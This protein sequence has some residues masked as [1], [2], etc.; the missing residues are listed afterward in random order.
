MD[1]A[2]LDWLQTEDGRAAA[3]DASMLLERS[4][5][6]TA[7]RRLG[8]RYTAEQA[9]AAV[10]LAAGRRAA[11]GKIED[12][13]VLFC[14]REA[15]EQASPDLVAR[16]IAERFPGFETVADLGCGMG[17]DALAIARVARVLAVDR[18]ETRLAMVR[19]NAS[20]RGVTGRVETLR[21]DLDGWSPPTGIEAVWADPARRDAA[22]RRL[23]PE[24]WSPS[25]RRVVEIASG[26]RGAGIKL[27]PGI[28][29]E[30]L[31]AGGEI[32]FVSVGRELKAAVLWVGELT[33][34]SRTATV[35]EPSRSLSG[36]PDAGRTVTGEPGLYLY[37]PDPAVGR[38][39][40]VDALAEQLGAWKLDERIAYLTSDAVVESPFARR[41]RVI[42]W[43]AFS[44]RRIEERLRALGFGRV[45]VGRRGSPVETNDLER[46]LN[47]GLSRRPTPVRTPH[48]HP[49]AARVKGSPGAGGR[50]A[51]A[52]LTRVRGEHVALICERERD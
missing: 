44:A 1:A 33:R 18:D 43:S 26:R 30:R 45:E 20:V 5:E 21:A 10:A 41:F 12:A 19:A 34:A 42:E 37:D 39:G 36:E 31:P 14:D 22:G 7:L 24:R 48:P 40:L 3:D 50:V 15:A 52:I 2:D 23:E 47:R 32:E 27:A 29:L 6:L 8:Q 13:H 46:R 28:D 16:H 17:G 4:G 35:L 9:R 25:L 49:P 11:R 38:A 51:S